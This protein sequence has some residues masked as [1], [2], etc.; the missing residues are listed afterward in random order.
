MLDTI[1]HLYMQIALKWG[2]FWSENVKILLLCMQCCY[3]NQ[4]IMSLN[5]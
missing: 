4:Y 3:D 5:M 1:C 2:F